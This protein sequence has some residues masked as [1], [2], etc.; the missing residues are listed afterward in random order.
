MATASAGAHRHSSEDRVT[1]EVQAER[2]RGWLACA[3]CLTHRI[4]RCCAQC[5]AFAL[6]Q[7][8][9]VLEV[10]RRARDRREGYDRT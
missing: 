2:R 1:I 6:A 10:A 7:R 3:W 4:P 8:P 9:P 5:E